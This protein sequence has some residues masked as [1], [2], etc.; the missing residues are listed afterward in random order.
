MNAH[1][2]VQHCFRHQ[3]PEAYGRE[4]VASADVPAVL[5]YGRGSADEGGQYVVEEEMGHPQ[6]VRLD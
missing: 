3:H 1:D 5:R 2:M 6:A 4:E